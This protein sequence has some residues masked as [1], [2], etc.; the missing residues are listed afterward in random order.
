MAVREIACDEVYRLEEC[1]KALAEHHNKVSVNFPGSFP[2]K[3]YSETLAS[4]GTALKSGGSRIAVIE[5]QDRILGFCKTDLSGSEGHVDFLVVLKECRGRGFGGQLMDWAVDT[6]RQGGA[7]RIEIRVV[8]G[9]DAKTFYEKYGF[10]TVSE[11]LRA[12]LK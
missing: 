7:E 4:F 1:L 8:E 5:E 12:D 10:L 11:I 6:L 3:P 9:N 2:K